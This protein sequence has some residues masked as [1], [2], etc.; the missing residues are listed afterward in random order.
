MELSRRELGEAKRKENEIRAIR[1]H[2]ARAAVVR[3]TQHLTDRYRL[4]FVHVRN[5]RPKGGVTVAYQLPSRKGDAVMRV[6]V[7]LVHERDSYNKL[8]GRAHAA[9]NFANGEH[10]SVRV[11]RNIPASA[12]LKEMFWGMV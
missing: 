5:G 12:F 11:P 6:S 7:A 8:I 1:E 9:N 4:R 3:H 2:F 10:I